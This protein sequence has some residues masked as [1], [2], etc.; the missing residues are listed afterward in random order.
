MGLRFQRR[1]SI[2]PGL[3]VNLSKSGVGLSLGRKGAWL[4]VGPRGA[5]ATAGLPGTGL[6]VDRT[7]QRPK[8]NAS[9]PERLHHHGL[10]GGR[11]DGPRLADQ[12]RMK[13]PKRASP[14]WARLRRAMML[15]PD[16]GCH[17]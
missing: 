11:L 4:T 5:R 16:D 14:S 8:P 1:I 17:K 6:I 7:D 12:P 2:M 9:P 3:R 13:R 15:L 10:G